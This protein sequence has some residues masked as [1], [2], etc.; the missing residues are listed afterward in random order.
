[1]LAGNG[2]SG[3]FTASNQLRQ[4]SKRSLRCGRRQPAPG[5]SRV[6]SPSHHQRLLPTGSTQTGQINKAPDTHSDIKG[7][8]CML[9][10]EGTGGIN[11]LLSHFCRATQPTL[12]TF[13]SNS[14]HL[15]F[16]L[17]FQSWAA[18]RRGRPSKI[19][20]PFNTGFPLP[21]CQ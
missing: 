4:H 8:T 1:M 3:F 7:G 6:P 13:S 21:G 9:L 18:G 10:A 5:S 11:I 2:T 14:H 20:S 17:P 15:L 12:C 16:P 19:P